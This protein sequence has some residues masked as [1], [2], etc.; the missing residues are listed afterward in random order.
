MIGFIVLIYGTF[1][2]ND[3]VQA[4]L[5]MRDDREIQLFEDVLIA[6]ASLTLEGAAESPAS[7]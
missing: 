4:P 6:P 3:V 5:F 2:F 1:I 7:D